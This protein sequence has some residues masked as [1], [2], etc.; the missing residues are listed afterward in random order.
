MRANQQSLVPLYDVNRR[1]AQNS[2]VNENGFEKKQQLNSH[3]CSRGQKTSQVPSFFS[4]EPFSH[5]IVFQNARDLVISDHELSS[6]DFVDH[7]DRNVHTMKNWMQTIAEW[8]DLKSVQG[9]FKLHVQKPYV[10]P[11]QQQQQQQQ[12]QQQKQEKQQQQREDINL[13][14]APQIGV[15]GESHSTDSLDSSAEYDDDAVDRELNEMDKIRSM[16]RV[17][18]LLRT[19]LQTIP[20]T[21]LMNHLSMIFGN[22]KICA[23][24]G[25]NTRSTR[26]TSKFMCRR[27]FHVNIPFV[28]TDQ[29]PL[30]V[31]A[32]VINPQ[33]STDRISGVTAA[34][35]SIAVQYRR[36]N[37]RN[38]ISLSKRSYWTPFSKERR[39][40]YLTQ[41][42]S[43]YEREEVIRLPPPPIF[44][45]AL[46][47]EMLL[48][49]FHSDE[50]GTLESHISP[51]DVFSLRHMAKVVL[52]NVDVLRNIVHQVSK[53]LR[54]FIDIQI[55]TAESTIRNYW[56]IDFTRY[57]SLFL[58]RFYE[59]L[60]LFSMG[61]RS[62][63]SIEYSWKRV[64]NEADYSQ[65]F[66][67][68]YRVP[69]ETNW[70]CDLF[71]VWL[72]VDL[73]SELC[74]G[75]WQHDHNSTFAV[76]LF[77]VYTLF[78]YTVSLNPLLQ[79]LVKFFQFLKR[80]LL[81]YVT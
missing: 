15:V 55:A 65:S 38:A 32:S 74:K 63:L 8:I 62:R 43:H 6:I 60:Y 23:N 44:T 75:K 31:T 5:P 68:V 4:N 81:S 26:L 72:F 77:D 30:Y 35:R 69:M 64:P 79:R 59:Q 52:R 9:I 19:L 29:R 22:N 24:L 33:S 17:N 14:G 73:Y 57:K 53:A 34:I 66:S 46:P 16:M 39:K 47:P 67:H 49:K 28:I 7:S 18:S 3:D 37:G 61:P 41:W 36:F 78:S 71:R 11:Q 76:T 10:S 12:K 45:S 80:F 2:Y 58:S 51:S 1:H 20:Q 25:F 27:K 50:T 70:G 21:I 54:Y 48:S 13:L 56:P 42:K 40:F